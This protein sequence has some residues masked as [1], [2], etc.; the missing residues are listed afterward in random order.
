MKNK[1][2]E[3][4][5]NKLEED[6]VKFFKILDDGNTLR[7]LNILFIRLKYRLGYLKWDNAKKLIEES[8]R[9]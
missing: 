4:I 9:K 1:K 7:D 6:C 2:I 8:L 5:G 3:K